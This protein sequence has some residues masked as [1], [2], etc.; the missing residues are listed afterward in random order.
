MKSLKHLLFICF[1]ALLVACS[2]DAIV[3]QSEVVPT[4]EGGSV[5]YISMTVPD[6]EIADAM[7]RSKLIDDVSHS[8]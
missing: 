8:C 6:I 5:D 7:T 3:P 4:G 2:E 1:L